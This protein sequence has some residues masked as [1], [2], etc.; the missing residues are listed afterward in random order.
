VFTKPK[1][2]PGLESV[3]A[4]CEAELKSLSADTKEYKET[5]ARYKDLKALQAAQQP[6][7]LSP[8]AVLNATASLLGILL[9]VGY[10]HKNVITSKALTFVRKLT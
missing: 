1:P 4:D 3:I 10:E 8:D 6:N 7:G 5:L 2:D 9:I